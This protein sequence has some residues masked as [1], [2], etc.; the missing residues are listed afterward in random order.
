VY[1]LEEIRGDRGTLTRTAEIIGQVSSGSINS[2]ADKQR[3]LLATE[4]EAVIGE[5][6]RLRPAPAGLR[7]DQQPIAVEHHTGDPSRRRFHNPQSTS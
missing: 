6:G 1:A 7:V 3:L 2:A 5:Q 4:S